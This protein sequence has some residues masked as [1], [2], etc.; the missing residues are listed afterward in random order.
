IVGRAFVVV[1]AVAKNDT[2]AVILLQSVVEAPV[3]ND[4]AH[5]KQSAFV[6]QLH[7]ITLQETDSDGWILSR[8][9]EIET[10]GNVEFA[11]LG[12]ASDNVILASSRKCVFVADSAKPIEQLT[13][14]METIDCDAAALA[15]ESQP[16]KIYS[17]TQTADDVTAVFNLRDGIAK[18]DIKFSLT[19]NSISLSVAD[20]TLLAG[21]LSDAVDIDAST[22]TIESNKL[23]LS[24]SKQDAGRMWSDVVVGDETGEYTA[25]PDL[26]R[27]IGE[28]LM[29][30]TTENE[31]MLN[32]DVK[33]TYNSEELEECDMVAAQD[34]CFLSWLDD[35]SHAVIRESDLSGRQFLF[36]RRLG[37]QEPMSV[38]LRHDVDGVLWSFDVNG[39]LVEHRA[40]FNAFGYVQASK[41]QRKYSTCAPDGSYSVIIDGAKHA[42]IYWQPSPLSTD[43]RNRKNGNRVTAV[44]KQQLVTLPDM[45]DEILGFHAASDCLFLLTAGKVIAAV[46]K[47]VR[48]FE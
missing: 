43:L 4:Q 30:Y 5:Q 23:E 41:Q 46:L 24:L 6:T 21:Q 19:S 12:I 16:N 40:T 47:E 42:Y 38:C 13:T 29:Q 14:A 27:Q 25:D 44:A 31:N 17:W 32:K 1:D 37:A 2:S 10:R 11:S 45:T 22:W 26:V 28:R 9:R 34:A 35:E 39:K 36:T 20:K 7:W 18:T 3:P 8:S 48:D 15:A 33:P